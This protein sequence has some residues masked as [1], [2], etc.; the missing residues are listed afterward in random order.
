MQKRTRDEENKEG[1]EN[2]EGEEDEEVEEAE[3]EARKTRKT[4]KTRDEEDE[5]DEQAEARKLPLSARKTRTTRMFFGALKER[6]SARA[7]GV[8]TSG[9]STLH[10]TSHKQ[11]LIQAS[12]TRTTPSQGTDEYPFDA[13][14]LQKVRWETAWAGYSRDFLLSLRPTRG[15]AP[16][17]LPMANDKATPAMSTR[18]PH[19]DRS[20][21]GLAA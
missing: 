7:E 10:L 8:P 5:E 9:T 20:Q 15:E 3:A 14:N 1:E 16:L 4:R 12:V 18:P 13:G 19:V 11:I 17:R 2:E 6:N 21:T